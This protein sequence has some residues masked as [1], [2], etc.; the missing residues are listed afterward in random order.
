MQP[1]DYNILNAED[2]AHVK[3]MSA[4]A[5]EGILSFYQ[6]QQAPNP[7]HSSLPE[8]AVLDTFI[9][10][11]FEHFAPQIP[12][13]HHSL[14]DGD[15]HWLLVLAVATV[16][17]LRRALPSDAIT[18]LKYDVLT[19]A[20]SVL[21]YN[22]SSMFCGLRDYMIDLQ[23]Q[24]AW[25]VTLIQPFMRTSG[26]SNFFSMPYPT[27]KEGSSWQDWLKLEQQRRLVYC[28]WMFECMFVALMNAQPKLQVDDF[29]QILPC[30]SSL[31]RAKTASEW[32]L[33]YSMHRSRPALSLRTLFTKFCLS[34]LEDL[35]QLPELTKL[36]LLLAFWVE[37]QKALKGSKM[38]SLLHG[39]RSMPGPSSDVGL[40]KRFDTLEPIKTPALDDEQLFK[41][42]K[43]FYH[44]LFIIRHVPM[45]L[46]YKF[47]GMHALEPKVRRARESVSRWMQG[48]PVQARRCVFH[49]ASALCEIRRERVLTCPQPFSLVPLK[50]YLRIYQKVHTNLT[51]Q[52]SP[53]QTT[54]V[55]RLD[56]NSTD[57]DKNSELI[58]RWISGD[59]TIRLYLPGT[60]FFLAPRSQACLMAE[61]RRL[62]SSRDLPGWPVLREA[63]LSSLDEVVNDVTPRSQPPYSV[64]VGS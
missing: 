15:V 27:P 61:F 10:L 60:G 43:I 51:A 52:P 19:V 12:F 24:H 1:L 7:D 25:L 40:D 62:L 35:S 49:A 31:W 63:L 64:S 50:Q 46:M 30:S 14:F 55:L 11:Y 13:L 6:S 32:E 5:Y 53:S 17:L 58:S 42:R 2:F 22:F 21:L 54:Q 41:T 39:N 38:L 20:Q 59:E 4:R 47:F 36:L 8:K 9:Q 33:L 23:T 29:E 48:H 57:N 26:D 28:A 45:R 16:D 37:E 18:A 44:I 56:H 3:P 34:E